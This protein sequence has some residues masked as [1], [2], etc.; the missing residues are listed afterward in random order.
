M[1]QRPFWLAQALAE[2]PN[3]LPPLVGDTRTDVCIVGGGYT[4]LWTALQLKQQAPQLDV[5][6]LESDTCGAGAS[7][8]NGG[9]VLSW[10]TKFLTLQRLFGEAEAIR[11]V[12]ASED[13][14]GQIEAFTRKHAIECDLRRDGVLYTATAAAQ[15]GSSDAVIAELARRELNTY[16][17]LT[18]EDVVRRAGSQQHLGG[19]FS[20]QGATVQ[21]GRLV[22]GL[23][24]V[25]L[26]MGVR[27]YEQS[28][29][30]ALE[31]SATPVVRTVMGRVAARQVVLALNAWMATSFPQFKRNIVVVSSDMII[32]E[33]RPER[34]ARI[35][36]TGGVAVLDSRTF[37]Y[38][39]H[40]TSD[41][42]IMLGKGGNTFA[43]DARMLP[44]FDQPSPYLGAMTKALA[45][46]FPA[47][48]DVPVA[49]SWNGASDRSATGLPFFGRLN[50]HPSI[51]YGFGYS[52]NG[53]GP[54]FMGGQ[55]LSSLVLDQDNAWTRS[56]LTQ[57]PRGQFPPEPF[58]YVG[59]LVVRNAIRRKER[60]QDRNLAPWFCDTALSRLADAAGKSDHA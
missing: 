38:Y 17:T 10:A 50:Q 13:A 26:A 57:G 3:L 11:L 51:F 58:R 18:A 6:I 45:R 41:G 60:A 33:A 44:V 47:F 22:R 55:I 48:A 30:S 32:T 56:G 19:V 2:D 36:L 21:P 35:G 54:T 31:E 28:A 5:V 4:G 7:G 15:L 9:C 23:R 1:K 43:Y 25:A 16:S 39:Y 29:M 24:R 52:G 49:A 53:V 59:S 20:P 12:R 42:R 46:F 40:N 14:I 34:L 27:I 8:R 37:V